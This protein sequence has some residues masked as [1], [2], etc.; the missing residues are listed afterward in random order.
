MKREDNMMEEVRSE[1]RG[2][3]N[4]FGEKGTGVGMG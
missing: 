1:G 4:E 2:S 3:E